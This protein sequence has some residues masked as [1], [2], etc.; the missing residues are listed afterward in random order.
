PLEDDVAA[1]AVRLAALCPPRS[2]ILL[3]GDLG[4]GKTVF[5]RGV[6]RGLGFADR[7]PSPTYVLLQTLIGGRLPLYHGDLYR[8]ADEEELEQLGL[9][10]AL[11]DEAVVVLEWAAA[12]AS[13]L[14]SDRLEVSL[15]PLPDGARRV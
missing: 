2:L 3:S 4:A 8:L 1:L 5:A 12:F 10:D 14:P 13:S 6:A 15:T 9:D 7:V 11:D